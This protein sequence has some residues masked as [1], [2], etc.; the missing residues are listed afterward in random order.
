MNHLSL[1]ELENLPVEV[2]IISIGNMESYWHDEVE[3]VL[4][5]SGTVKIMLERENVILNE[6]DIFLINSKEVHKYV[7]LTSN[8]TVLSLSID[9]SRYDKR[10]Y[11]ISDLYFNCNS[12]KDKDQSKFGPLR[13]ILA[14]VSTIILLKEEGFRLLLESKINYLLIYLITNFQVYKDLD[15]NKETV[16]KEDRDRI[17]KAVN[18]IDENFSQKITLEEVAKLVLISPNYLSH[19]FT[20]VMN[21]SFQEYIAI[22]R[23]NHAIEL[24][25]S[26][27]KSITDIANSSGYSS[28]SH[29]NKVFKEKYGLTPTDYRDKY[30]SNQFNTKNQIREGYIDYFELNK[31]KSL[32][33]LK[34]YFE[35]KETIE[36]E[37]VVISAEKP[38]ISKNHYIYNCLLSLGDI[39]LLEDKEKV[40]SFKKTQKEI[41]FKYI[42]IKNI[43]TSELVSYNKKQGKFI[44]D[45]FDNYMKIILSTNSKPYLELNY[46]GLEDLADCK[47]DLFWKKTFSSFLEHC[48]VQ[49][50]LKEVESWMFEHWDSDYYGYEKCILYLNDYLDRYEY[51]CKEIKNVSKNI[52]LGFPIIIG[53]SGVDYERI[54]VIKN[55]LDKMGMDL[56]YIST[57]IYPSQI[58]FEKYQKDLEEYIINNLDYSLYQIII[59]L[60]IT[61]LDIKIKELGLEDKK[62]YITEINSEAFRQNPLYDTSYIN[63]LILTM[64]LNSSESLIGFSYWNLF[65]EENQK[66]LENSHFCGGQGIINKDGVEKA[67]YYLYY[68]LAKLGDEILYID[69]GYIVAKKDEDI[70]ILFYNQNY[71]NKLK[72]TSEIYKI[73]IKQ[74]LIYSLSSILEIDLTVKG[75]VG[76]YKISSYYLNYQYGSAFDNWF[77]LGTPEDMNKEELDYIKA[78]SKPRMKTKERYIDGTY[79]TSLKLTFDGI[80]LLVFEKR[81]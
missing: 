69:P 79:R 31:A 49:Y 75:L 22:N 28:V 35:I 18:Y 62:V 37:S 40:N 68:L 33:K 54:K 60:A 48:I 39:S 41:K 32:K 5:L 74:D 25:I 13:R 50:G 78:V 65:D 8:C 6:D 9:L 77:N 66:C 17:L 52:K 29:F 63:G 30:R 10:Y 23:L 14:E 45:K 16:N 26:T 67:S 73:N 20:K 7:K 59:E 42:R 61:L 2:S 55:K 71:V 53:I 3:I 36:S 19:S 34:K 57:H 72:Y 51:I 4:V 21:I 64:F 11:G 24:I 80:K 76:N 1:N 12:T 70:Q 44:W 81:P 46:L 43:F 58:Y 56:D 47:Y 15:S 38:P 27:D